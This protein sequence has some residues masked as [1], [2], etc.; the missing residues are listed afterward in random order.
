LF[1]SDIPAERSQVMSSQPFMS[2]TEEPGLS[3]AGL[4]RCAKDCNSVVLAA[5]PR[6]M[7]AP[8]SAAYVDEK[9]VEAFRRRVG[10]VYPSAI[11]IPGR[12]D[13][14]LKEDLDKAV[15]ALTGRTPP[16]RRPYRRG[17]A[18]VILPRY[19]QSRRVSNGTIAYYWIPKKS[20]I[21]AGFT[22]HAEPLGRELGPACIRAEQLNAHLDDW[23]RDRGAVKDLD[24]QPSFGTLDWL[25]ER[26]FRSKAFERVSRRCQADYRREIGLITDEVTNDGARVG[27]LRLGQISAAAVDKLYSRLL[28]GPKGKRYRQASV[29]ITRMVWAW[30]VV[31]RLYRDTVPRDNPFEGVV[32]EASEKRATIPAT[33][34]EAYALA[35][36]LRTHGHEHLALAP[37]ICFEWLQRPENVLAGHIRWPD[38]R[39]ASHPKHVQIFHHKTGKRIWMPLQGPGENVE[40]V[41]FYPELEARLQAVHPR[42]V[43]IVVTPGQRGDPRLYARHYAKQVVRDARR[44]AGLP[45]HLTLAACRGG[46][47]ELGDAELTE[48]QIRS[49]SGHKTA[50]AAR[51][52]VKQTEKQRLLAARKRRSHVASGG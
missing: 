49:L 27:T 22:L 48:A 5:W 24:L 18:F 47:T 16:F 25:A 31:G 6:L 36:A 1:A 29:A 35:D 37:L 52:Y 10:S 30:E 50:E 12:G 41:L 46:M 14:W 20:G 11:R 8:T 42:G 38:W 33:R 34:E 3:G 39:P 9:S 45:E 19:M 26:Y 40:Q 15:I 4:P 23:R 32:R 28:N 7:R 21:A 2:Q 51:L 44:A 17:G 43:S 13:V